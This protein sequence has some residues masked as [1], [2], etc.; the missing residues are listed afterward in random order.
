MRSKEDSHD[1]RYFPEPDLPPLRVEPAWLAAIRAALPE[2][3]AARR[4]RYVDGA[5]AVGL[6][7]GR[8]RRR[9]GDV[10]RLRGD[11]A[12][13]P[14]LPPKEVANL[15]SG[16]YARAAKATAERTAD[17]LVGRASGAELADL[18]RRVVGGEISRA[19]AREVLDEHVA[20]GRPVGA[21]VEAR[22]FR[23]I[24]DADALDAVV[25]GVIA[26]NPKAV[27][28]FRAGKPTIGF[29]VGQ[30]MKATGGQANA[31]LVAGG[32][33]GSRLDGDRRRRGEPADG[34]GQRRP[35]PGRRD[36]RGDRLSRA[37]GPWARYRALKAQ[38]ANIA[39]YEAWRGGLR[40]DARPVRRSPWRSSGARPGW[41]RSSP[42]SAS[43]SW[44]SACSSA[45]ARWPVAT[46]VV[47][48]YDGRRRGLGRRLARRSRSA[49]GTRLG[50]ASSS[51]SSARASASSPSAPVEPVGLLDLPARARTRSSSARSRPTRPS[52][53]RRF[54]PARPRCEA[55]VR[56][57]AGHWIWVVTTNDNLDALR[58]YQRRGYRIGEVRLGAVDRARRP[59]EAVDRRD[60]RATAS[61]SATRSSWSWTCGCR[62]V[63][64]AAA[65]RGQR[66]VAHRQRRRGQPSR[67]RRCSIAVQRSMTTPARPPPRSGPPPS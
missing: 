34:R 20:S 52:P 66:S 6:R 44:S 4:E 62:G 29:L 2:L 40:D 21:I 39:R 35:D 31:A 43:S 23:Q 32:A 54:R 56:P 14:D 60:R 19:N 3:P 16:D 15:V 27:A 24:S 46:L 30:V 9:P 53:G 67:R 65:D 64:V 48:P 61:R 13:G 33:S 50:G 57:P 22:G 11:P 37:R 42:S 7:R 26:D 59:S 28:D 17:G 38:D 51:T 55:V 25:D 49:A 36:P 58:F 12:A 45:E 10:G 5:R 41:G 63:Q 47:R 8:D 18:V 1:Y